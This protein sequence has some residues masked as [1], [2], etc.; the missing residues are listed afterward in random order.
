MARMFCGSRDVSPSLSREIAAGNWYPSDV[1]AHLFASGREACGSFTLRHSPAWRPSRLRPLKAS[2]NIEGRRRAERRSAIP[3]TA[4]QSTR[5]SQ[6]TSDFRATTLNS[7]NHAGRI[8]LEGMTRS[9]LPC[10]TQHAEVSGV[11]LWSLEPQ[12]PV[13]SAT[14]MVAAIL[15]CPLRHELGGPGGWRPISRRHSGYEP[16][17]S[18]RKDRSLVVGFRI[19]LDPPK[20]VSFAPAS[21]TAN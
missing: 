10:R 4:P 9:A 18:R 2:I 19:D 3:G 12:R 13:E 20:Q 1:I 16:E 8:K 21:A 5:R 15:A 6:H 11:W 7:T 17:P 14:R